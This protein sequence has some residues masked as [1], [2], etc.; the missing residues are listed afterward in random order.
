MHAINLSANALDYVNDTLEAAIENMSFQ[1]KGIP[2]SSLSGQ[3]Y[4]TANKLALKK[5][6]VESNSSFVRG[7]LV[8]DTLT[9]L[10]LL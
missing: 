10:W 8:L 9:F 3:L 5:L 7:D 6:F 4:L 1:N 2:L